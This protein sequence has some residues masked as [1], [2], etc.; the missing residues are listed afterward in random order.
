M[1]SM[2]DYGAGTEGNAGGMAC[3]R[4]GKGDIMSL[5]QNKRLALKWLEVLRTSDSSQFHTIF[6][7]D[8][9]IETIGSMAVSAR[10]DVNHVAKEIAV[11]KDIFP[12][13]MMLDIVTMTAEDNRVL[14]ELQGRNFLKDGTPY[15]NRYVFV[16]E[17]RNGKIA[18][19]RE[20]Q[21]TA[22]VE[23]VLMPTFRTV[24]V[25]ANG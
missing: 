4:C 14:L 19:I 17:T 23:R 13:G 8:A 20:Y 3:N 1:C 15:P 22:L 5:E 7:G 2:N 6:T 12:K 24:G 9:V 25:V 11:L 18:E 21:D 10:K 16:L